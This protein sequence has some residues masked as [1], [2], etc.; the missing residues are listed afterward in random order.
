LS[1]DDRARWNERKRPTKG[2]PN[3]ADA[4]GHNPNAVETAGVG[5]HTPAREQAV[6]RLESSDTAV[7]GRETS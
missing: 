3:V 5:N 7:G 4:L 6:R 1:K 2:G